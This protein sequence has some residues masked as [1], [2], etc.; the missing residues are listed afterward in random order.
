MFAPHS[1]VFDILFSPSLREHLCQSQAPVGPWLTE[2][3]KTLRYNWPG[4]LFEA[5]CRDGQSGELDLNPLCKVC[6]TLSLC[7]RSAAEN[8]IPGARCEF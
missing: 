4:T 2:V 6:H 7:L 5:L 8:G 1:H 3:C